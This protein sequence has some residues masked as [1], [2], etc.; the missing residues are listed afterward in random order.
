LETG[1]S[2][3]DLFFLN[4]DQIF[5]LALRLV[6]LDHALE[7][8]NDV[9]EVARRNCDHPGFLLLEVVIVLLQRFH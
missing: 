3:H 6:D 8:E 1:R 5:D 2:G 4:F 7:L 9:L